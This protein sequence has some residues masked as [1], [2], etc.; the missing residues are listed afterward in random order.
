MM[1]LKEQIKEDISIFLDDAEFASIHVVEGEEISILVDNDRL[2]EL[3]GGTD[4]TLGEADLLFY[5]KTADLPSKRGYGHILNYDDEDWFVISWNENDG[6]SEI[7]L[8]RNDV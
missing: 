8:K 3:K 1:T 4:N 2:A 6:I 5:A 7:S